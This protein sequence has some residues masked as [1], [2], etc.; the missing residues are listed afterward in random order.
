LKI[1]KERPLVDV[2]EVEANPIG[3]IVYIVSTRDLP[4][5]GHAWRNAE[6]TALVVRGHGKG[7]VGGERAWTDK[8]HLT[9]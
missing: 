2:L 4:K 5:A 3:K 8:A 7:F 6:A 1:E 9:K